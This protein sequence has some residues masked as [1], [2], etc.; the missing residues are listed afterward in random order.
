MI[1]VASLPYEITL[2]SND[3][4]NTVC[5]N[6]ASLPYEITLLSNLA[7]RLRRWTIASLPY[8]ITLLSNYDGHIHEIPPASLPYEITLLSNGYG[9]CGRYTVLHYHTKLHYSQTT[10]CNFRNIQLLHYHTKLHYSQTSNSKS[11]TGRVTKCHY[12]IVIPYYTISL[13]IQHN[14]ASIFINNYCF[15]KLFYCIRYRA[16]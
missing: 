8:E 1:F 12:N 7:G 11:S 9:C 16:F 5:Q 4:H 10:F 13:H 15:R 14:F 2:L 6:E 3:L